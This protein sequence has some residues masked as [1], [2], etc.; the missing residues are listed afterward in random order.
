MNRTI[1]CIICPRGCTLNVT[2]DGESVS[3]VGH[4]CKRG[5]QY[6]A[7]ECLHP[8]RT[9]TSTIRVANRK[10]TM[11][12]VKTA[13]PIPKAEMQTVMQRI[14]NTQVN[15]PVHIGDILIDNVFGTALVATEDIL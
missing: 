7:E 5:E 14:R 11:V 15:A 6:G 3:V 9:V 2:V 13:A 10:D 12:S 8:T 1:T 4:G